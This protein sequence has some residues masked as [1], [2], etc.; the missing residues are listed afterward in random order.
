MRLGDRLLQGLIR[1]LRE[2]ARERK[3]WEAAGRIWRA[4]IT[5]Q[6]VKRR[7]TISDKRFYWLCELSEEY[8]ECEIERLRQKGIDIEALRWRISN[9]LRYHGPG[10]ALPDNL[11]PMS[12][13]I[14]DP[15]TQYHPDKEDTEEPLGEYEEMMILLPNREEIKIRRKLHNQEQ[16]E[17][18]RTESRS[19]AHE[20]HAAS[21]DADKFSYS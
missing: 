10:S 7:T 18:E 3:E 5:P 13:D 12:D 6:P 8:R 11:H 4:R 15:Y 9:F 1:E 17:T 2:L 14:L 19:K 20:T 16:Y 21:A